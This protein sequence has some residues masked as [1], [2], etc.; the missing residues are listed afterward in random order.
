[1]KFVPSATTSPLL[2]SLK[3]ILLRNQENWVELTHPTNKALWKQS[4]RV[5][6]DSWSLGSQGHKVWRKPAKRLEH[7]IPK[8]GPGIPLPT[9]SGPTPAGCPITQLNSDTVYSEVASDHTD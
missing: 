5:R 4:I 2:C 8:L 3:G 9:N 1:M 6:P 7:P